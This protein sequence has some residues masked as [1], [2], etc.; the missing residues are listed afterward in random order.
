MFID[1]HTHLYLEKFDKDRRQ[2]VERALRAGVEIMILPAIRSE[3]IDAQ[4]Q[5]A[6]EYPDNILLASGLHPSDVKEDFDMELQIV[7][8]EIET[9][10]YIAVGEIGIDLY[11]DK[12]FK[13]Q[14]KI[15]YE[16][17]IILAKEHNLPI[18]IHTRNAFPEVFEIVDKHADKN[19]SGVFH[20]F[21]GGVDEA[22]K[23]MRYGTF[24]IGINGIV[25]FKNSSLGKTVADIPLEFLLLETDA[26]FLAPVPKRGKRNESSYL[27]YTAEKI[28]GLKNISVEKLAEITR[29]NAFELFKL[30]NFLC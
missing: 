7:R 1:T 12:S 5:M 25:T 9:G 26:P 3:Y 18:I 21:T 17:Q 14:Q 11:W 8:A 19:L 16:Q 6:A 20:S 27:P 13:E 23:I 29:R 10:K 22:E 30:N 24:K 4:K 2:V 15:A 28:A